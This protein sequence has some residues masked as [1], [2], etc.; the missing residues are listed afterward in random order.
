MQWFISIIFSELVIKAAKII[1]LNSKYCLVRNCCLSKLTDIWCEQ[2][3]ISAQNFWNEM[4]V[5][6]LIFKIGH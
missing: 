4:I 5:K 2:L 3:V 6:W 1:L